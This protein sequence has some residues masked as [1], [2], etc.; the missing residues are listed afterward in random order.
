[1]NKLFNLSLPIILCLF[2]NSKSMKSDFPNETECTNDSVVEWI[3]EKELSKHPLIQKLFDKNNELTIT[4]LHLPNETLFYILTLIIHDIFNQVIDIDVAI[5]NSLKYIVL[6]TNVNKRFNKFYK[7]LLKYQKSW[8]ARKFAEETLFYACKTNDQELIV[9]LFIPNL[10]EA[11]KENKSFED[12]IGLNEVLLDNGL[13]I[14]AR[15]S[16]GNT[17][18]MW[19][20]KLD[21]E[22]L[23]KFLSNFTISRPEA[24]TLTI[25]ANVDIA[26]IK[27]QTPLMCASFKGNANIVTFLLKNHADLHAKDTYGQNAL[28][29]AVLN[30]ETGSEILKILL[31]YGAKINDTDKKGNTALIRISKY[32]GRDKLIK[33]LLAANAKVNIKN[34]DGYAPLSLASK[35]GHKENVAIFLKNDANSNTKGTDGN[36]P[37]LLATEGCHTEIVDLL[38]KS[39]ANIDA[40]NHNGDSA[41]IIA[42]TKKHLNLVKLLLESK[43]DI[44]IKNN[45]NQTAQEIALASDDPQI[46]ELFSNLNN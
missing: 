45:N 40:K 27:G 17:G 28:I 4:I 23:V 9:A 34:N 24:F 18:F 41:L 7:D 16:E 21:H 8:I 36:T 20:V 5:K 43:A 1:M 22:D 25:K 26:D 39:D 14:D 31:E 11:F 32:A 15:D 13:N 46:I 42:V 35:H 33:E 44:S 38:L 30:D 19:A 6:I 2:L 12:C 10:L 3:I 29:W 37:L